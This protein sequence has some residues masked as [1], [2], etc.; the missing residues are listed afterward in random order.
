LR[1]RQF[2]QPS[3]ILKTKSQDPPFAIFFESQVENFPTGSFKTQIFQGVFNRLIVSI[4]SNS[5]VSYFTETLCK[6]ILP[7][8]VL[9]AKDVAVLFYA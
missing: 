4:R 2:P 1:F 5:A 7:Q 6:V 8:V 3:A 9:N